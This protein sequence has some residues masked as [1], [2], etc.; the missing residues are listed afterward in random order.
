MLQTRILLS[1]TPTLRT[2]ARASSSLTTSEALVNKNSLNPNFVS[3]F[4]DAEGCFHVS[5]V[6]KPFR[7]RE[8]FILIILIAMTEYDGFYSFL[9]FDLLNYSFLSFVP[10]VTYS[11]AVLNKYKIIKENR[12]KSGIYQ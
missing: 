3:G 8:V 11:N 7:S 12:H 5:I 2:L 10:V 4:T 1:S 9:G 6:D